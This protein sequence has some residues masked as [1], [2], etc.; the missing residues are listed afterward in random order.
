MNGTQLPA[1]SRQ[2]RPHRHSERLPRLDELLTDRPQLGFHF[3]VEGVGA[4]VLLAVAVHLAGLTFDAVVGR[5]EHH[6]F[7]ALVT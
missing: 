4:D 1:N 7:G 6:C 5:A 3:F 2:Q